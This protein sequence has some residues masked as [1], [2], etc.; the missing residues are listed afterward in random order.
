METR[1]A[2]IGIIVENME[3]VE[4][5]NQILHEYGK[6]IVGR[7]GIPYKEKGVSIISIVIDADNNAIS[8]LSGKLGMLEGISVK[9][10]YSKYGK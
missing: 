6:Y 9:T 8:S 5:V 10:V 2:L 3:V 7:M 1:I 4:N